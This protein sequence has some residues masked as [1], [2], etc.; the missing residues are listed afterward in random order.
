MDLGLDTGLGLYYWARLAGLSG[1]LGFALWRARRRWLDSAPEGRARRLLYPCLFILLGF[2]LYLGLLTFF[3][4]PFAILSIIGIVAFFV[5]VPA[6]ASVLLL[7]LG[8]ILLGAKRTG[9]WLGAGIVAFVGVTFLWLGL[10]GIDEPVLIA[11]GLLQLEYL[12]VATIPAAAGILWWAYLPGGE[13][14]ES[15]FD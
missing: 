13:G 2:S 7:D 5:A 3:L 8:A 9:R 4:N 1:L 10:T 6:L 15:A 14:I 12:T 11:P